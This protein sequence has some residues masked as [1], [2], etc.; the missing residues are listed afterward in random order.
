MD[1][2]PSSAIAHNKRVVCKAGHLQSGCFIC[3]QTIR[4]LRDYG[5]TPNLPSSQEAPTDKHYKN[6]RLNRRDALRLAIQQWVDMDGDVVHSTKTQA[7]KAQVLQW[8]EEDLNGKI[9]IYS[10]FTS[11]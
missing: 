5:E 4:A 3:G 7:I 2:S 11:V 8:S 1:V 6:F 9:I 10:Q